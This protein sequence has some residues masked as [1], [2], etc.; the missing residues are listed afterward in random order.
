MARD[1]TLLSKRDND[2]RHDWQTLHGEGLRDDVI[3]P[4]LEQ[5]YYLGYYRL[6]DIIYREAKSARSTPNPQG[7]ATRATVL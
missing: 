2:I 1:S 6:R 5:K 4:R 7:N 3:F